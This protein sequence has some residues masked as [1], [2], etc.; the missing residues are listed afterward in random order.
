LLE[1]YKDREIYEGQKV[2]VYRNLNKKCFSIQDYKTKKVIAHAD[3]FK[4]VGCKCVV[5]ESGRQKV[6]ARKVRNVH[7]WVVGNYFP[8]NEDTEF[9]DEI[10]Y[11]PY[12]FPY[13]INRRSFERINS[14]N[15]TYF[16][17]GKCYE[18]K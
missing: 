16:E 4:I 18:I 9:L 10:Y 3:G 14:L 8:H 7:A 1:P 15:E 2:V 5:R 11:N 17:D 13:F 12:M 6:I